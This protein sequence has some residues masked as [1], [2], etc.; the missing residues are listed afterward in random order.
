MTS[1]EMLLPYVQ[2]GSSHVI[3]VVRTFVFYPLKGERWNK[4]KS[5]RSESLMEPPYPRRFRAP[6]GDQED[7]SQR[8]MAHLG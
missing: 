1:F 3:I 5:Y 2:R 4:I 7:R 6:Y 8:E